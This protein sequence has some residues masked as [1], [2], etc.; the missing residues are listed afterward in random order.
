MTEYNNIVLPKRSKWQFTYN[1]QS[2]FSHNLFTLIN[3]VLMNLNIFKYSSKCSTILTYQRFSLDEIFLTDRLNNFDKSPS[4]SVSKCLT[5]PRITLAI[6]LSKTSPSCF[7]STVRIYIVFK[8]FC[9]V[10]PAARCFQSLNICILLKWNF[11]VGV[12]RKIFGHWNRYF[13]S[14]VYNLYSTEIL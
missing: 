7:E 9:K 10:T 5:P 12:Q 2:L 11:L 6:I 13:Q 4:F 3:I 1:F 14:L 8:V